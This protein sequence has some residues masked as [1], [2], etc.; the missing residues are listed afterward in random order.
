MKINKKIKTLL[1]DSSR[2]QN[3]RVFVILALVALGILFLALVGDIAYRE[4][5]VEIVGIVFALVVVPILAYVGIKKNKLSMVT[6]IIVIVMSFGVIPISF[7]FGGGI[8]GGS[9]PWM[10]FAY[11]Y[12]GIALSGWWK[13]IMLVLYSG[14]IFGM[15]YIGYAFPY[16]IVQRERSVAFLD[17][18]LGV[19]EVGIVCFVM[20]WFQNWLFAEENKRAKEETKKVEELNN[21]QNRFFSSMSHEIRTPI[22]SIL[23]LNEIILRQEDASE[24]IRKDAGGIQG[25]GRMLLVIINDILDFSKI[26]AGKMDIVPVNY[27]LATL[28][29]EIVNMIWMRAQQKGLELKV[30]IDPS[31]PAELFG[32]EV[33][34]KQILINLLNNAVKYTMEGSVTLHI[35]KEAIKDDQIALTFTVADTGIGIKQDSL[36]YLFDAFRRIDEEKN[37][38]IEGTGLGLSIVRQLVDLMGGR[39]TVNSV[40]TQGSTFIVTLWQTVTSNEAIGELNITS[41]ESATVKPGNVSDFTAPDARVL[42]VDDNEMNLE[43]EAKLLKGTEI[44]VDTA[45]SGEEALLLTAVNRYDIIFMDHLMPEMDGIECMQK[46][47]KQPAGLNNRAPIVVL[48]ANAGGENKELYARSG[49]EDYL[50]KPVSGVQLEN[51]IIAHIPESKVR[52]SRQ[53]NLERMSLSATKGYSRKIP[54]LVATGSMTDLPK[55]TIKN[56]QIDIIP[57][58]LR[59]GDKE[60]YDGVETQA[61]EVL[62]YVKAG[63][64]FESDVPTVAEFESFFARELKKAINVIYISSSAT[65]SKEYERASKAAEAYGNVVVF[66]SGTGSCATGLLVL[67][68]QRMVIAGETPERI[69]DE[70]AKARSSVHCSFLTDGTFYMRKKD[71]YSGR[72]A[73]IMKTFSIRPV[74]ECD[75]GNLKVKKISFGESEGV[76][77]KFIDHNLN[78]IKPDT[79]LIFVIYADLDSEKKQFIRSRI[80]KHFKFQ[81]IIFQKASSVLA[82]NVGDGSFGLAFFRNI[83]VSYRLGTMLMTDEADEN[84]E[85]QAERP[86]EEKAI[87]EGPILETDKDIFDFWSRHRT[88]Y[89]VEE[90]STPDAMQE[91]KNKWYERLDGINIEMAL[92]NS[93]S[94]D[95]FR[96][97]LKIFY[98]SLDGKIAEISDM[99][100]NGDVNNYTIKVHALKSS[101]KLIGAEELSKEAEK[102]EMAG[103]ENDVEY[104]QSNHAVFVQKLSSFK[105]ILT[106]IYADEKEEE[107]KEDTPKPVLQEEKQDD[108][109]KYTRLLVRSIL[110]TLRESAKQQDGNM[111]SR[112]IKEAG[113]YALPEDV[114][115]KIER[116]KELNDKADYDGIVSVLND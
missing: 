79:D 91:D 113:D 101:A 45:M 62:R 8:E 20:T 51:M 10:V 2:N 61:D 100:K 23:G 95:T 9:V 6:K 63:R 33:R 67:V 84:Q 83:G 107:V 36:P 17:S 59:S 13:G 92:E 76:Y 7:F 12:I 96:S 43:V 29:S 106:D 49:F 52:I 14:A 47:R 48:T 46:I 68:A 56:Y 4:N 15:Y 115:Q 104:I 40:Y 58:I 50:V 82:L 42:I 19:V 1:S 90:K 44:T 69:L 38:K 112:T 41:Y 80:E 111:I 99:Y 114:I 87:F 64:T 97:L 105:M 26:E 110:D 85:E 70:L 54:V 72:V 34:I 116:V 21:S 24:E 60:Y 66:D 98:K 102:L 74:I 55:K 108:S 3:E 39:I 78:T 5:S 31:I 32:D 27:N 11:L 81:N 109:E 22:N 28:V 37:T 30:E 88:N 77:R 86:I 35:E 25:A 57:F 73:D 89:E 53:A 75:E 94:E 16:L 65:L 18:V 103:K 93:G 71:S